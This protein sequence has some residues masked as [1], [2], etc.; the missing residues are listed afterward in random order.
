MAAKPVVPYCGKVTL[1]SIHEDPYK[2]ARENEGTERDIEGVG[3]DM[4]ISLKLFLVFDENRN[5]FPQMSAQR[6]T[7]V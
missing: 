6:A 1:T 3:R 5:L 7:S 2:K 4:S